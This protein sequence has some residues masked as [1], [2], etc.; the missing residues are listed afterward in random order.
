MNESQLEFTTTGVA[1][2]QN[3]AILAAL[4]ARP[5]EWV[6]MTTLGEVAGCWAVH[7]R[8]ADL[9]KLGYRVENRRERRDGQVHSW[10][11]LV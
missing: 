11:R 10:Y 3:A 4:Q 5:G 8:C 7:S 6:P 2:G 1:K 9:R